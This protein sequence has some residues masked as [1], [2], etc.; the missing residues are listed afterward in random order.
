[1]D[2]IMAARQQCIGPLFEAGAFPA[3]APK[4]QAP[5]RHQQGI[6]ARV[7][8]YLKMYGGIDAMTVQKMGTTDARK[9]FTRLREKGYLYPADDVDGHE[10]RPNHSGQGVYRW[11][12]WTGKQ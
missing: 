2:A 3:P 10:D 8:Q 4:E 5:T 7:I 1:M 12:R 11:H 6:Q 9:M